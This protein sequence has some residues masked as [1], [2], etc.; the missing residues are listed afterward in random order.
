MQELVRKDGPAAVAAQMMPKLLADRTRREDPE[1]EARVRTLIEA[2]TA[3]AIHAAIGA[4][5][6]RPDSTAELRAVRV[7]TLVIV[8]E[9]DVLTPPAESERMRQL[10]RGARLA[11]IPGAGH[12][13]SLEQP[14]AFGG[15]LARFLAETL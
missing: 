1:V 2:N 10:V 14:E 11:R 6:E 8:G 15:A 7:P 12:L 4:M 3:G 13:S 5:L 9:E